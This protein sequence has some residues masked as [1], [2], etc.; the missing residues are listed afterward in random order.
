MTKV[1]CARER[2][3]E[4]FQIVSINIKTKNFKLA[5]LKVDTLICESSQVP[6]GVEQQHVKIAQAM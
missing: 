1:L 6:E 5:C 3:A 2:K 4:V